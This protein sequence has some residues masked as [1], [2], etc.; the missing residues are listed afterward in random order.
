MV[1][2]S[3]STAVER[4]FYSIVRWFFLITTTLALALSVI[5]AINGLSKLLYQPSSTVKVPSTSYEDFQRTTERRRS[6]I[7]V[8][9]PDNTLQQKKEAAAAAAAEADFEARLKPHLDAI[10]AQLTSYAAKTDQAKP[11]P[12]AIGS[13][14][15]SNMKHF[16]GRDDGFTW[17]Y[18]EGLDRATRDLAA[19]GDRLAKLAEDDLRRVRWNELIDWYTRQY[20][21]EISA[22]LERIEFDRANAASAAAEVPGYLYAA[23]VAFGVFVLTTLLLLL[24]RIELNTRSST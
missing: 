11:A 1:S 24:L 7:S 22:Q 5:A 3:P 9:T 18:V 17:G 23:A 20:G 16:S 19:D 14:V 15:R 6:D 21:Q 4:R 8:T 13:Y 2:V 12:Q 10:I